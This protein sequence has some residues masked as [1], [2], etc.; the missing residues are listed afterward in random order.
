MTRRFVQAMASAGVP[1]SEIA[2]VLAV[3]VPTVRKHYRAELRR[4][5]ATVETR[6]VGQLMRIAGGKDGAAL[7]ATMFALQCRFGWSRY[8]PPQR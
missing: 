4:G 6:L 5:A 7:K 8:V 1:Q 3:T 2:A